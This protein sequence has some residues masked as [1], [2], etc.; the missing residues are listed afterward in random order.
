[1]TAHVIALP[2]AMPGAMSATLVR[3]RETPPRH[4]LRAL[5]WGLVVLV[6]AG[7]AWACLARLDIIASAGGKLVP[8]SY[9]KIVQPADAGVVEEILVRDGARVQTGQVL[10]RMNAV[11]AR[12]DLKAVESDLVRRRMELRRIDAELGGGALTT[13]AGDDATLFSALQAQFQANIQAQQDAVDH[14]RA[15]V[16]RARADLGAAQG[17]RDKLV[18]V[19]PAYREQAG[20]FRQLYKD[21]YAGR[22]MQL[23][24][25]RELIEKERDL[26]TQ[27]YT[28]G[29]SRAAIAQSER[30]LAQIRS[31]YQ[32]RLQAERAEAQAQVAR[33]EQDLAKATRRGEL[34]ELRA[35]QDGVVKDL[36][37]HTTGTVVQPGTVLLSLVPDADPLQAEVWVANSDI[38]FVEVGQTV[39][40]K[41]AAYSFQ[42]YGLVEGRVLQ[43][44]ADATEPGRSANP[45]TPG[46]ATT[47]RGAPADSGPVFK[48]LVSL[49]RQTLEADGKPLRFAPGMAV[50]AEIH[51][52]TR[53]VLAYLLSPV[54]RVAHDA[55]RER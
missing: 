31:G 6:A 16:Q 25:E 29:A 37:T 51:Q 52:G 24:K 23:D 33:L 8:T 26:G 1:M 28:I 38:G 11:L 5:T 19:L 13:R 2:G 12:A 44:S 35:P 49:D 53:S 4:G 22:L 46:D 54:Q 50:S 21:G 39:M 55:A 27:A 20:A 36:A 15:N 41:L 9:V 14:E 7:L 17:Q 40:L 45:G 18:G 42:K 30:R 34:L 32:Q 10:M 43:V 47:T 3:L 48:V